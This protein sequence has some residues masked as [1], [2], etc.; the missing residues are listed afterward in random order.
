LKPGLE[1]ISS[2]QRSGRKKD[3]TIIMY[4]YA[5]IEKATAENPLA[6]TGATTN[7][8]VKLI[9]AD[10][11]R[12]FST[13]FFTDESWEGAPTTEDVL[14]YM[15]KDAASIE[16]LA[17]FEAWATKNDRNLDSKTEERTFSTLQRDSRRLRKFF[18]EAEFVRAV[19]DVEA[20]IGNVLTNVV[21]EG[22]RPKGRPSITKDV[23]EAINAAKAAVAPK[24][25]KPKQAA[26]TSLE[27]IKQIV[28][29]AVSKAVNS[30]VKEM[31]SKKT[32]APKTPKTA[33][34]K[35]SAKLG[36]KATRAKKASKTA[37][38]IVHSK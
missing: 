30:A 19:K 1:C 20:Y 25:A 5:T 3:E 10:E 29:E 21:H 6:T 2:P 27:H 12:S 17:S 11:R 26:P 31:T 16:G 4:I 35:N 33:K 7:W 13:N 38:T 18:G 37:N 23:E 8:E 34:A 28:Q 15:L 36:A 9:E 14:V 32:N 22:P 24:A